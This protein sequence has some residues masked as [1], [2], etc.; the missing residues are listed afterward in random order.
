MFISC[1][2]LICEAI[3]WCG[4]FDIRIFF[5]ILLEIMFCF[6][7]DN[8]HVDQPNRNDTKLNGLTDFGKVAYQTTVLFRIRRHMLVQEKFKV[9]M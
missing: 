5:K 1:N 8:W 2:N 7:A 4:I 3:F 6:R 9:P